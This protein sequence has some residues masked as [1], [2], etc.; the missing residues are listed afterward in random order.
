MPRIQAGMWV[1]ATPRHWQTALPA[2][3]VQ[4]L[5][6]AEGSLNAKLNGQWLLA[7]AWSASS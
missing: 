7:A 6:Q 3:A 5:A 1:G 4:A 2:A